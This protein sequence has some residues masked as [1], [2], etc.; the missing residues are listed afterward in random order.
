MIKILCDNSKLNTDLCYLFLTLGFVLIFSSEDID[1]SY[2]QAL[3]C[4]DKKFRSFKE[5]LHLYRNFSLR[6]LRYFI[7]ISELNMSSPISRQ[8]FLLLRRAQ[9]G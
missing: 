8:M 3:A 7:N 1:I 9:R 4:H 5:T 2:A 6:F